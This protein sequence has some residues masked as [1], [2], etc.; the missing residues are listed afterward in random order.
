V[1]K[2]TAAHE[3]IRA[4]SYEIKAQ[5]H[6]VGT[7]ELRSWSSEL[8]N[9]SSEIRSRASEPR[10]R[11]SKK[12]RNSAK[13]P[14]RVFEQRKIEN[15]WALLSIVTLRSAESPHPSY[16]AP[17]RV[18]GARRPPG[19]QP[20]RVLRRSLGGWFWRLARLAVAENL[21]YGPGR[22]SANRL[23]LVA[24]DDDIFA[25]DSSA[26]CFEFELVLELSNA[27]MPN[28]ATGPSKGS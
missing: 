6:E 20:W 3:K 28:Q 19:R 11:R 18:T 27:L 21:I 5:N 13:Y 9:Q 26:G 12:R 14:R 1:T 10:N 8:R 4:Q 25:A 15:R 17:W 24:S 2:H 7:R 22:S 23:F 16:G